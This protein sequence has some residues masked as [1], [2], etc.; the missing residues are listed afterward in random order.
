[1]E[2]PNAQPLVDIPLALA[3]LAGVIVLADR[4]LR[5]LAPPAP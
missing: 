2:H 4:A 5:W 1:M 3:A